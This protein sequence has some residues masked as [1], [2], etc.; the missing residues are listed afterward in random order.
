MCLLVL[1]ILSKQNFAANQG[2]K[3]WYKCV[4]NN[5][6]NPKLDPGEMNAYIKFGENMSFGSQDIEQKPN[7]GVNPGP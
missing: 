2:P 1:K 3:H 7:F 6:N 4:K 5:I